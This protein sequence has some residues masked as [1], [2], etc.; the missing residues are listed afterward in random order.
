MGDRQADIVD[1]EKNADDYLDF[2]SG[3]FSAS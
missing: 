3:G 1:I 2:L